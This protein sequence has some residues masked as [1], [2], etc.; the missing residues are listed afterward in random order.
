MGLVISRRRGLIASSGSGGLW[1]PSG[2]IVPGGFLT[3]TNFTALQKD[4]VFNGGSLPTDWVAITDTANNYTSSPVTYQPSVKATTLTGTAASLGI[5]AGGTETYA[6]TAIGTIAGGG[7]GGTP[8]FSFQYGHVRYTAQMPSFSGGS[9]ASGI[10]PG[11][12]L[13]S[14]STSSH[15][16]EID[17]VEFNMSAPTVVNATMHGE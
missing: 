14:P 5:A 4:Y 12:W 8:T 2:L 11:V 13:V 6:G 7:I 9:N 16:V 10:W 15:K 3:P 1:T 17:I